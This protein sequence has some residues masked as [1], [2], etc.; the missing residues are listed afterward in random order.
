MA[1]GE[2]RREWVKREDVI[3]HVL[4]GDEFF[5]RSWCMILDAQITEDPNA[6][7]PADSC[8]LWLALKS[9]SG[10][11]RVAV[12]HIRR[13]RPHSWGYTVTYEDEGLLLLNCPLRLLKLTKGSGPYSRNWR[14][15]VKRVQ[16]TGRCVLDSSPILFRPSQR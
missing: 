8:L 9:K 5:I 16:A 10:S 14:R 15:A 7:S 4:R 12:C 1:D 2:S 13:W 3:A 11:S 6:E